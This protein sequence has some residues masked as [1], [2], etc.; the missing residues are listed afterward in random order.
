MNKIGIF[1]SSSN[2]LDDIYYQEAERLGRW[3]GSHHKTLV[4]GGA[5]CGLMETLAKTV[6]ETGGHVL[7]VVPQ[8]LIDRHRVSNYIDEQI[9]TRDLNDR[10]QQLIDQSDIIVALP[11]NV[12]TLDEVFTVMAANT[13]G[14]HPKKVLFWNINHF[15][16]GLFQ[17]LD[18][19]TE[20]GVV[21]KPWE[22]VMLKADTLD[23]VIAKIE[24]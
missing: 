20:T 2:K 24:K 21:N 23:E 22:E 10:K 18:G 15:W 13:I 19:L 11:G 14:I 1:Y 12:G 9:L 5:N 3:L 8:I 4:Y 6:H 7:G 17:M 16:D